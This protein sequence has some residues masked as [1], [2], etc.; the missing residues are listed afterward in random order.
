MQEGYGKIPKSMKYAEG[1]YG[2]LKTQTNDEHQGKPTYKDYIRKAEPVASPISDATKQQLAM[3]LQGLDQNKTLIEQLRTQAPD[4]YNSMAELIQTLMMAMKSAD[5]NPDELQVEEQPQD[6]SQPQQGQE[7]SQSGAPNFSAKKDQPITHG[8]RVYA[9]GSE[10]TYGPGNEKI[11]KPDGTWQSINTVNNADEGSQGQ[12]LQQ[13]EK[14]SLKELQQ[15]HDDLENRISHT[16][17]DRKEDHPEYHNLMYLKTQI[18]NHPDNKKIK[19]SDGTWQSLS[20]MNDPQEASQGQPLQQSEK[21]FDIDKGQEDIEKDSLPEIQKKTAY[22][23]A[24]RAIA[25][26]HKLEETGDLKWKVDAEEYRHEALEHAAL[27]G[28]THPNVLEEIQ[29]KIEESR[30]KAKVE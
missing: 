10:R 11:K 25:C 15:D 8:K 14:R 7:Q 2:E 27:I 28:D 5:I 23:W 9:P 16:Q 17:G 19:K 18:S 4:V 30:S 29:K 24:A 21:D 3:T 13:S 26:Y 6:G 20:T 12:P 22:T 1:T